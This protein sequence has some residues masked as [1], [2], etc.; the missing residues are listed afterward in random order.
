MYE[1]ASLW[2]TS[3]QYVVVA[4]LQVCSKVSFD[5]LNKSCCCYVSTQSHRTLRKLNL[6]NRRFNSYTAIIISV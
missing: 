2:S 4:G 5:W 1:L 3:V 6:I